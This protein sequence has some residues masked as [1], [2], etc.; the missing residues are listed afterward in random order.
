MT[1]DLSW[2]PSGGEALGTRDRVEL[3]LPARPDLL[4]LVRMTAAAVASRADFGYD[5]IE[6]LRLAIDELCLTVCGDAPTDGRLQLLFKWGEDA[7]EVVGVYE[8]DS[9]EGALSV[10][11]E[12]A[13]PASE[14]SQRI[15]DALVDE[16]GTDLIGG[17]PR[18][19]LRMQRRVSGP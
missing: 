17:C 3:S 8:P 5:Q 12:P 10:D 9:G 2:A 15:L 7:I 19:W 4:F 14:L 18:A 11:P 16:H 1:A 13:Q 6:D